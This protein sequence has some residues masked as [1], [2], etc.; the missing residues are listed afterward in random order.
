MSS[1]ARLMLLS[2]SG[3][4]VR[5]HARRP[6][7]SAVIGP[8]SE[9]DYVASGIRD[10][11]TAWVGR[12]DLELDVFPWLTVRTDGWAIFH[13]NDCIVSRLPCAS[14]IAVS[15]RRYRGPTRRLVDTIAAELRARRIV[16]TYLVPPYPVWNSASRDLARAWQISQQPAP[17]DAYGA[18]GRDLVA[19]W[20]RGEQASGTIRHLDAGVHGGAI[21]A[22]GDCVAVGAPDVPRVVLVSAKPYRA[23]GPPIE[24]H[25]RRTRNAVRRAV[26]ECG[27]VTHDVR[28]LVARVAGEIRPA[29]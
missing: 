6:S 5:R 21:W 24:Q 16:F 12:R 22:V 19:A 25:R 15:G 11:V 3:A 26:T 13:E 20:Q 2:T 14:M 17:E 10:L 29:H 7:T 9:G 23:G 28:P 4:T 1:G 8:N 18:L 27:L